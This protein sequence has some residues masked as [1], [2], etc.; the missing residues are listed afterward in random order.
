MS[1]TTIGAAFSRADSLAASGLEGRVRPALLAVIAGVAL[2]VGALV[3]LTDR[4]VAPLAPAIGA[5]AGSRVFGALGQWL[6]SF[7]HPFA[8]SLFSAAALP[9]RA[10]P[11]YGV[12]VAWWAVNVAFE[13]GQHPWARAP[14]AELL[15]GSLGRLPLT[16]PLADYFTRGTFDV[17]DI[18]AATAGALAAAA[19]LRLMQGRSESQHAQ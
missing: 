18:L 16:R 13:I 3:Y 1:D 9:W 12:C 11:R 19:V 6:P 15:Q 2:V 7:V 14:I 8:F 5:L 17:G 10:A 4:A